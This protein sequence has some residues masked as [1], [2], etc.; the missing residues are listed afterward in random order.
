MF[1]SCLFK[2]VQHHL[3]VILQ[4]YVSRSSCPVCLLSTHTQKQAALKLI[5]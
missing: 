5:V 4:H 1:C 3:Q 2:D